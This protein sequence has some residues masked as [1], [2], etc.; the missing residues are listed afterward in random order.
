M[1]P[2]PSLLVRGKWIVLGVARAGQVR[3]VE[4]G[5]VFVEDGRIRETG[6][7]QDLAPRHVGSPVIGGVDCIVVPGLVNAHHHVGLTPFQLGAEDDHLERWMISRLGARDVDVYLDTLYGALEMVSS[8]VTT[9]HHIHG[10]LPGPAEAWERNA[11]Q[12]IRAYS[13]VG[14]RVTYCFSS[15]DQN[16]L[17][18]GDHENWAASLPGEL[19]G[20]VRALVSRLYVPVDEQLAVLTTLRSRWSEDSHVRFQVSP[21]NL[22]WCSDDALRQLTE[23]ARAAR[24]RIHMHLLETAHQRAYAVDRLGASAVD[25]LRERGVLG[26]DVTLAHMVWVSRADIDHLAETGTMISHQPSSNLRLGS[27]IAPVALFADAGVRVA[28]GIDEAGLNDDHDML[29]EM[30]L[31][32]MLQR[33]AAMDGAITPQDALQMATEH[34]AISVGYEDLLGTLDIG[35]AADLAVLSWN[36]IVNPYFENK[37]SPI[38]AL[39]HR[40]KSGDVRWVV[41]DGTVVYSEGEF[42]RVDRADILARLSA[43]FAKPLTKPE[44]ERFRLA[45]ALL[46]R[47]SELYRRWPDTGASFP[48]GAR[49]RSGSHPKAIVPRSDADHPRPQEGSTFHLSA[50]WVHSY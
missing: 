3:I 27:G 28:I 18:Y 44:R 30:R 17:V 34:G 15:R 23:Y 7:W 43:S 19:R 6:R 45:R 42:T 25:A 26:E 13:D 46:P 12:V 31:A 41:V 16:F 35:R 29:Q 14:M 50:V 4:D 21:A 8:G 1:R 33:P 38:D 49:S 37:A 36:S 20:D 22:H 10:R 11:E 39:V 40:A 32:M 9:V 2:G 48:P 47:V 5:G 24:L